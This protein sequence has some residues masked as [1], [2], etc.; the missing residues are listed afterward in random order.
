MARPTKEETDTINVGVL[1]AIAKGFPTFVADENGLFH[2]IVLSDRKTAFLKKDN[3]Q[4]VLALA[5][6]GLSYETYTKEEALAIQ[7]DFLKNWRDCE[8]YRS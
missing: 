5:M 6:Y 4:E 3:L 2:R 8:D 1:N 7:E